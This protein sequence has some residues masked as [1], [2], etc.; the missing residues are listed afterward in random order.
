MA[1]KATIETPVGRA[2]WAHVIEP[3]GNTTKKGKPKYELTLLI[4][5]ADSNMK[6]L[7][8]M[9]RKTAE[10]EWGEISEKN[11]VEIKGK[12]KKIKWPFKNGDKLYEDDPEVHANAKGCWVLDFQS[13]QKPG[14][15][16]I[17]G[18]TRLT[19]V[20]EFYSGC[21]CCINTHC[22]AWENDKAGVGVSFGMNGIQKIKDDK[23]F[24]GGPPVEDMFDKKGD[25]DAESSGTDDDL[26][27]ENDDDDDDDELDI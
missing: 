7:R 11:R 3:G 6:P 16:A 22:F 19:T 12:T 17:D 5:K 4:P 8:T 24:F 15:V 13:V 9:V 14:I 27:M 1:K 23:S 26:D 25:L 18:S 2:S 21:W 10:K 20:E